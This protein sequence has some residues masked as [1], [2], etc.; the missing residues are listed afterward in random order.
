VLISYLTLS[1][2]NAQFEHANIRLPA[3]L[4]R[5]LRL[6]FVT[7][8]MHK[9]HHSR[10]L[11]ETDMNYANLLSLWDR[12]GRTY[13][14]GPRLADIHCGLDGFDDQEK[15]SVGGLLKM[16]FMTSWGRPDAAAREQSMDRRAA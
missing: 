11:P 7:P 15:Q 5:S 4:D 6:L 8:N 16:P 3:T 12:I 14:H 9:V 1:A 13:S 10:D 2:L